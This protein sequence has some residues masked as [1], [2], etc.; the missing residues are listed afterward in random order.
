[1]KCAYFTQSSTPSVCSK[2]KQLTTHIP[3]SSFGLLNRRP[4]HNILQLTLLDSLVKWHTP[5]AAANPCTHINAPPPC[6][7]TIFIRIYNGLSA[8][9]QPNSQSQRQ[10]N[11]LRAR[12][13]YFLEARWSPRR[14]NKQH[15]ILE[16]NKTSISRK[17]PNQSPHFLASTT[18]C[19]EPHPLI[20]HQSMVWYGN[21]LK[22]RMYQAQSEL[23]NSN[24]T[25]QGDT[26][27][28]E[29]CGRRSIEAG[30][31]PADLGPDKPAKKINKGRRNRNARLHE[32][33]RG[34]EGSA[35][36]KAAAGDSQD[37]I[38]RAMVDRKNRG[39]CCSSQST[40]GGGEGGG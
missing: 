17:W 37:Q 7:A 21:S 39:I 15:I 23:D 13:P 30:Q 29:L 19:T 6:N 3:P 26:V 5:I 32:R 18:D 20:H 10:A 36:A 40:D 38:S 11:R 34:G 2:L 31:E 22:L 8:K 28:P 1:M 12:N 16:R 25:D 24:Y 9:L 14:L 27:M 35:E 33:E 4:V